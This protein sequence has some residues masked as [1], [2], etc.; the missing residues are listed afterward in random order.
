MFFVKKNFVKIRPLIKKKGQK[1]IK[2]VF[3][4]LLKNVV[5]EL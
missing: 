2:N 5:L 4:G 3:Q 1:N